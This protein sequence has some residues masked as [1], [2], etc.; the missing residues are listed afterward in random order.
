MLVET[1]GTGR[2]ATFRKTNTTGAQPA[3]FVDSRGGH[4]IWADHNSATGYAAIIQTINTANTNAGMLVESIGTGPSVWALK[5]TDAV[6]GD[7]IRA[8]NLVANGGAGSFAISNATNGAATISSTTSGTGGAGYFFNSN[9]SNGAATLFTETTGTGAALQAQTSSGF[10]AIY[11]R[12]DGATNGNAGVFEI[13]NTA[14]TYP[15][16][17]ASTSGTGAAINARHTGTSGDAFFAE[18]AG[19]TGS[20]GNF[21]VSNTTNS[22]SALFAATPSANGTAIGASNE[23]NGVAFAIWS[24]GLKI[25][26]LDV[27][28]SPI[29]Q[30]ASAYRIIAGTS[31]TLGY[32]PTDGEVFM[33]Y[34]ESGQSVDFIA[35]G[36]THTL[37][38][39]QGQ[40][41]I[42]FPGGAVRGF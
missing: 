28:T 20:A 39:G 36:I 33:V 8:E 18:H 3:V 37:V 16:L 19:G 1:N 21:R 32:T 14:N 42:V 25:V 24:G 38:N 7:A 9:I 11:A 4:G 35:S 2:A 40:T 22:A 31:F 29:D 5:S 41:F 10:A 13:V 26:A 23:A 30:R 34:N 15:A 27:T 6:S 12:R 17:Q